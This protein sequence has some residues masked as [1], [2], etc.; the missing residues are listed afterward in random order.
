MATPEL[1]VARAVRRADRAF[2]PVTRRHGAPPTRRAIPVAKRFSM[3][4]TAILYQQLHGAAARAIH[5]RVEATLGGPISAEGLLGAGE[6]TLAACG[7]SA[8]KRRSLFDLAQ[9][10]L[11]G[12]VDLAGMGR[13]SDD[14]VVAQ[15]VTVRGIGVWTAQM[16]CLEALARRDV[17]PS[18]DY[19]VRA[20]W[21]LL[22]G[23]GELIGARELDA[24]GDRFRPVR[25]AVAW[26]CWR[27]ANDARDERASR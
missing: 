16:F 14:E 27:A 26:Y 8:P 21:T 24:L 23:G 9:R 15:L 3:L 20:G 18:S 22:H 13:R 5:G 10:S 11:D 17:W 2:G 19:G 25:S 6:D 4:A 1:D 7:V 12:T